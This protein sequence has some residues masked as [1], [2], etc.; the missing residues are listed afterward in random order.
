MTKQERLIL[1]NCPALHPEHTDSSCPLLG[2][3]DFLLAYINTNSSKL[4]FDAL[5]GTVLYLM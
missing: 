5:S 2:I 4:K 1:R 3:D